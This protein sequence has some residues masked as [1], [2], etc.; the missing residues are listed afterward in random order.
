MASGRA[1]IWGVAYYPEMADRC[2][3]DRAPHQDALL[4]MD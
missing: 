2:G 4:R 3:W 1:V